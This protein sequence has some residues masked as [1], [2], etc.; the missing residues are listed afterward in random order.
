[1]LRKPSLKEN[2]ILAVELSKRAEEIMFL[3]LRRKFPEE[4]NGVIE[5]RLERW[6][7][8]KNPETRPRNE[9]QPRS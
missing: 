9:T 2:L 6:I 1:M 4:S 3:N 5:N 7:S 8:K